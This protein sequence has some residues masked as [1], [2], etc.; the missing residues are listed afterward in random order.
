MKIYLATGNLN[1]KREMSELFPNHTIVIPKDEGIDFEG[2]IPLKMAVAGFVYVHGAPSQTAGV[3]IRGKTR[4][5]FA[6]VGFHVQAGW[7]TRRPVEVKRLHLSLRR[8]VAGMDAGRQ[9][10]AQVKNGNWTHEHHG[11][12]GVAG[13]VSSAPSSFHLERMSSL[14]KKP[15]WR[16]S[17]L[18][19][20]SMKIW[21]GIERMP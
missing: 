10:K 7:A 4:Y 13:A 8:R 15:S 17:S 20:A 1:K 5:G 11:A 6:G 2:V 21:V 9:G 19:L 16:K 12:G 14:G 18:P 3:A